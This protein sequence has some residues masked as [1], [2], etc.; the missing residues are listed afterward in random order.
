ML[1]VRTVFILHFSYSSHCK[2]VPLLVLLTNKILQSICLVHL[3]LL[4][5]PFRQKS[6]FGK[7]ILVHLG[8]PTY[9]G[10]PRATHYNA[11]GITKKN[12][13]IL[14]TLMNKND[15]VAT[16]SF[17]PLWTTSWSY[18]TRQLHSDNLNGISEF[19]H[20]E[21]TARNWSDKIPDLHWC[22]T[23]TWA[24]HSRDRLP[25]RMLR[26]W[27]EIFLP[28]RDWDEFIFDSLPL[29]GEVSFGCNHFFTT[30]PLILIFPNDSF[31]MYGMASL[32]NN[33]ATARLV[34]LAKIE[35]S[36]IERHY[37]TSLQTR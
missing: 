12:F 33:A 35:H 9:S 22:S 36:N 10:T 7:L 27:R 31:P 34:L 37:S 21:L 4:I 26:C 6:L 14:F 11:K 19:L 23:I 32:L 16:R 3:A 28:R 17:A 1:E 18:F 25:I 20:K 29:K 13:L 2:P 24:P 8:L 5:H 15:T 30:T